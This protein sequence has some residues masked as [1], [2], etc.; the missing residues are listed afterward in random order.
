MW[1]CKSTS[2]LWSRIYVYLFIYPLLQK[3]LTMYFL[4]KAHEM[5]KHRP[6]YTLSPSFW[7][8]EGKSPSDEEGF[9]LI[10][11]GIEHPLGIYKSV[12]SW[13][14][15]LSIFFRTPR[16]IAI[17]NRRCCRRRP[18][19]PWVITGILSP[20]FFYGTSEWKWKWHCE[21]RCQLA[22]D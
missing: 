1:Y 12:F 20:K 14:I 21:R 16:S 19:L 17:H 18:I 8:A 9:D 7:D 15:I 4:R 6:V 22:R 5:Y 11:S 2:R 13:F 10:M 3:P